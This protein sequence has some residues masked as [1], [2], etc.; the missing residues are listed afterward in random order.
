MV[1]TFKVQLCIVSDAVNLFRF[2]RLNIKMVFSSPSQPKGSSS[3]QTSFPRSLFLKQAVLL[4]VAAVG[5]QEERRAFQAERAVECAVRR[6][7]EAQRAC[8][9]SSGRPWPEVWPPTS[10]QGSMVTL[11][12]VGLSCKECT[13]CKL[14][15]LAKYAYYI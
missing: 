4:L 8:Q 6:Q 3:H 5:D 11:L 1:S 12:M 13:T 2:S 15:I 10:Q 14:C 7:A 9:A